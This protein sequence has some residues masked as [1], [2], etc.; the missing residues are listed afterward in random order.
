[1]P[2]IHKYTLIIIINYINNNNNNN[3][4]NHNHNHNHHNHNNHNNK[5]ILNLNLQMTKVSTKY[6]G[7]LSVTLHICEPGQGTADA[8]R[9]VLVLTIN[10]TDCNQ[11][12]KIMHRLVIKF[13][14][15]SS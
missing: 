13:A 4:N 14:K 6:T 5:L 1:M 3:N 7:D 8:L 12:V 11:W 9:E 10:F 2:N 15:T